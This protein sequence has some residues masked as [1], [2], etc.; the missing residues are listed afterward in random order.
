MRRTGQ[1]VGVVGDAGI[2]KS[3]LLYEFLSRRSCQRELT[4][5]CPRIS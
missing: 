4:L 2:G 1:C 5:F 3:R